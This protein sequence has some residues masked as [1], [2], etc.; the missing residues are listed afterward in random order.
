MG[1]HPHMPLLATGDLRDLSVGQPLA[2]EIDRLPLWRRQ[3]Q[4]QR[5]DMRGKVASL[6]RRGRIG[7]A[8]VRLGRTMWLCLGL[9]ID[10]GPLTTCPPQMIEGFVAADPVEPRGDA[11]VE[12]VVPLL[13]Q[14]HER[15][16]HGVPGEIEITEQP[17][18]IAKQ[19]QLVR[20]DRLEDPLAGIAARLH[21]SLL[22]RIPGFR[23]DNG[24]GA[25]SLQAEPV[26]RMLRMRHTA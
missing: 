21:G 17:S 1:E 6:G 23:Q 19:W 25:G 8:V 10:E 3:Q 12:P 24:G 14:L 2:P 18:R 13:A 7:L 11:A 16:L 4:E 20:I 9:G 22:G 26:V 15:M 5:T